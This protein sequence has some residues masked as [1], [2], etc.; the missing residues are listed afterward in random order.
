MTLF[1]KMGLGGM[2]TS[3]LFLGMGVLLLVLLVLVISLLCKLKKLTEKYEVFMQGKPAKSLEKEFSGLFE[4][5]RF[6][7]SAEEKDKND[8]RAIN[9]RLSKAIVKVG[10]NKYDAYRESGGKLSYALALLD[11]HDNGILINAIQN[12]STSYSYTKRIV[13]GASKKELSEHEQIALNKAL[14]NTDET[15]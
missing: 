4:D 1:E 11:E 3:Y 2:D 13:N 14:G 10:L 9:A 7:K 15:E 12:G 6:L 5:V 8:I